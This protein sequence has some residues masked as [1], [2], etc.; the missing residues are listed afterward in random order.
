[1]MKTAVTMFV[2]HTLERRR[3]GLKGGSRERE[4]SLSRGSSV[5]AGVLRGCSGCGEPSRR[6]CQIFKGAAGTGERVCRFRVYAC[7]V[8]D[9]TAARVGDETPPDSQAKER[10]SHAIL[11]RGATCV[12]P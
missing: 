11:A 6:D 10:E 4:R 9:N 1:M 3:E 12:L 2:P 5:N 7:I 8:H